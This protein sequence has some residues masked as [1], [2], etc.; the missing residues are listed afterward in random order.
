MFIYLMEWLLIMFA[1]C[2]KHVAEPRWP[3][4]CFVVRK[5]FLLIDS[6]LQ[7]LCLVNVNMKI[8]KCHP[9]LFFSYARK[10]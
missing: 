1:I 9:K 10:K 4:W 6:K 3:T 5:S 7:E 8:R 2:K